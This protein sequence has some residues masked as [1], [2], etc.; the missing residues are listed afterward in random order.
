MS[1]NDLGSKIISRLDR[2][3]SDRA[4]FEVHWQD[5][6]EYVDPMRARFT[7]SRVP[8]QKSSSRI[9]DGTAIYANLNLINSMWSLTINSATRWFNIEATERELNQNYEAKAW[10][11]AS[12][13]IMYDVFNSHNG[14]FYASAM[15]TYKDMGTYG[16][17]IMYIEE[18]QDQGKIIFKNMPLDE[19]FI[20]ENYYGS[21]DTN[22]RRFQISNRQ[23]AQ[24]WGN[25]IS[26]D[27]LD[28]YKK[29]PDDKIT[30]VHAVIP[31]VDLEINKSGWASIY[32]EEKNKNILEQGFYEEF[33]FTIS[34]WST[35]SGDLYGESPAM[36]A[37]PDVKMVNRIESDLAYI[38]RLQALGLWIA[39]DDAVFKTA[40]LEP[41]IIIPGALKE[42]RP[43]IMQIPQNASNLRVGY[44]ASEQRRSMIRDFF[45]TNLLNMPENPNMT[46]TEAMIREREQQRLMAPH[47]ARLHFEFL[48]PLIKR[49][50]NICLKNGAFPDQPKVLWNSDFKVNY[51]APMARAQKMNDGISFMNY[52]QAIGQLAQIKP[53]VV[54]VINADG[55]A[56]LLADSFGIPKTTTLSPEEINN[57]RQQRAEQMQAEQAVAAAEPVS[58]AFKNAAEAQKIND[59]ETNAA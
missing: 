34:R 24:H 49:V 36:L 57:V 41:G 3:K 12:E 53:E 35:R 17:G 6:A 59:G 23:C 55:S 19:C 30:I 40:S 32:L 39:E 8:G 25:S 58:R 29:K 43:S 13:N 56:N 22:I 15:E 52:M 47:L 51:V 11:E 20:A 42:G 38:S 37:L 31:H 1:E 44:E 7:G 45:H 28:G 5:I 48:D 9:F 10:L 4:N 54:D 26:P 21:I 46:A 27:V 18:R 2:M 14:R 33:P 16:T 50:F